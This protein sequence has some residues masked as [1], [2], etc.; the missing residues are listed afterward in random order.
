M[1]P[2]MLSPCHSI[3]VQQSDSY[4]RVNMNC[5]EWILCDANDEGEERASIWKINQGNYNVHYYLH[6]T[7]VLRTLILTQ[8]IAYFLVIIH[9]PSSHS[10]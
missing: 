6:L 5:Y 9:Y 10:H 1:L 8:H 2:L 4:L 7:I 3:L